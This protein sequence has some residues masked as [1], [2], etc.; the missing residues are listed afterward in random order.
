MQQSNTIV[1]G[2]VSVGQALAVIGIFVALPVFGIMMMPPVALGAVARALGRAWRRDG[3]VADARAR[4]EHALT[5]HRRPYSSRA[6][7]GISMNR[8]LLALGR[9]GA[10]AALARVTPQSAGMPGER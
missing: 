9:P 8:R 7:L 10:P 3:A 4:V 1:Q 5:V 6:L 2:A